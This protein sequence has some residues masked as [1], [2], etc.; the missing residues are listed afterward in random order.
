MPREKCSAKRPYEEIAAI[1]HWVDLLGLEMSH[2]GRMTSERANQLGEA[3]LRNRDSRVRPRTRGAIARASLGIAMVLAGCTAATGTKTRGTDA[4]DTN[5]QTKIPS[6]VKKATDHGAL[7]KVTAIDAPAGLKG[8]RITFASELRDGSP[9]DVTG[10]VYIP[11][12]T[13]PPGG[14]PVVSVGHPTVGLADICAPSQNIGILETTVAGL[15]GGQGFATVQSDYPGLGTP[16]AHPFLDGVS[17][18]NSMLDVVRAA[19]KIDGV[20]LSPRLVTWGHSQGGHAALFAGARAADYTPELQLVGVVAGAPP[21]QLASL[22][23]DLSSSPRRGYITLIASGLAAANSNLK[24]DD[25]LTPEGQTITKRLDTECSDSV[26]DSSSTANLLKPSGLTKSWID[27]LNADEPGNLSITAPVFIVHGD[28]D[29]LVPV[30]SSET[31]AK[32]LE[33]QGANVERKVYPGASH[34]GAALASLADVSTWIAKKLNGGT[35]KAAIAQTAS[36]AWTGAT[37]KLRSTLEK[38]QSKTL[39]I[40]HAGG[41]QEAP[42]STLYAFKRAHTIGADVLEMD[43]RLSSDNQLVVFHDP[44]VD[45]TTDET[46]PVATRTADQLAK[47]DAAYWFAPGC[48]DCR[49]SAK[50]FVLRGVRTGSVAPP[51]S[52]SANEFGVVTLD[53]I[54]KQFPDSVLDI[55]IK[56]DG[57]DGGT[58]VAEALA[59]RLQQDPA[60]DRFLVV[61]FDDAALKTFR[62]AAPKIATSPGLREIAQYVLAGAKLAP[63]PVLQVPPS[64]QGLPVLTPALLEKAKADGLAIWVWPED[65][66]TDTTDTYRTLLQDRPNGIIAGRPQALIDLLAK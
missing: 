40:A 61:S 22:A 34:G 33:A 63:T 65:S 58:K 21:S 38:G 28:A 44:T 36:P 55:E 27:A 50:E 20:S 7:R 19:G 3:G 6:T 9:T 66:T 26:V 35:A 32:Q 56:A 10:L 15:F 48:W 47:L 29:D 51:E 43:V 13:A 4:G 23:G 37:G 14:W 30:A 1:I 59:K 60:P 2:H 8:F 39:V 24:L 46:G 52:T 12:K 42:H 57:P 49:T 41:E 17:S 16:G 5:T 18:G 53:T 62:A 11:D 25:I 45:R 31:L 54:I 64:A